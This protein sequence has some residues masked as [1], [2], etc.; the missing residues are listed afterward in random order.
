MR[1]AGFA[2]VSGI[3]ASS[4]APVVANEAPASVW[5]RDAHG[6][7][8]HLQSGLSCPAQTGKFRSQGVTAFDGAGFD[9]SCGYGYERGGVITLYL[10]RRSGE[11]LDDH[12]LASK[13]QIE[14]VHR[15]AV[16]MESGSMPVVSN[17][18][19]WQAALFRLTGRNADSGVWVAD[20]SGWT[21]KFRA[22]YSR[23]IADETVAAMKSLLA[24]TV[25]ART[26]L[27]ACSATPSRPAGTGQ[28][29]PD[30]GM[31]YLMSLG[32]LVEFGPKAQATLAPASWCAERVVVADG[33]PMVF[34]TNRSAANGNARVAR[35]TLMTQDEPPSFDILRGEKIS[36]LYTET[37]YKKTLG[38][39]GVHALGEFPGERLTLLSFFDGEPSA[40]TAAKVIAGA[41]RGTMP[42]LGEIDENGHEAVYKSSQ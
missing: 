39:G 2:L 23:E 42:I 40:E 36:K 15:D 12:F 18:L 32:A 25:A 29:V 1:L 9:V 34:W 24:G 19:A 4:I 7:F 31:L 30:N 17:D 11:S 41:V 3:F 8:T 38:A 33:L 37:L 6:G 35:L 20:Y 13:Q 28:L 16:A 22:T 21:I 26:H 5:A 27:Q 14:A 10:T